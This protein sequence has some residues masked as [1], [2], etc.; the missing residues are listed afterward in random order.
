CA[1]TLQAVPTR[2]FCGFDAW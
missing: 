1:S 2:D